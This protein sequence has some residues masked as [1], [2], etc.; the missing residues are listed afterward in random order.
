MFR[1]SVRAGR[2]Q[3][4]LVHAH[5]GCKLTQLGVA[6]RAALAQSLPEATKDIP[7]EEEIMKAV[8]VVPQEFVQSSMKKQAVDVSFLQPQEEIVEVVQHAP[9]DLVMNR[10]TKQV[11]AILVPRIMEDGVDD[12]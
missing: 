8:L 6:L 7:Q 11:V 5:R 4:E 9:Q 1:C 12:G 3:R 10:A 2:G